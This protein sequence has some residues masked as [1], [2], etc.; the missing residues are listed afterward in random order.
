MIYIHRYQLF[1]NQPANAKTSSL[2]Q[3]GGLIKWVDPE[4]NFG[5]A[6]LCPWP[7]LG[8]QTLEQELLTQGKLFQRSIELAKSDLEARKNKIKLISEVVVQ[9]HLLIQDYKSFDFKNLVQSIVKIKGDQ[10]YKSLAEV[11]N[12]SVSGFEK[13]RLD[14]NFCLTESE[15]RDFLSLLNSDL[16]KKIE[17]VEDPFLFELQSWTELNQTVRLSLDWSELQSADAQSWPYTIAKPARKHQDSFLYMTSSMDHPVG[18]AHGLAQ[19]Q[20]WPEKAHGFL[21][22]SSYQPTEF[23]SAFQQSGTDLKYVS[24]GFGIGFE[25]ALQNISWEPWIDWNLNSENQLFINPKITQHEKNILFELNDYFKTEVS[26]DGYFLIPSSG[27]SKSI[28][29]SVKLIALK[30][31]AVLN[32]ARRVN[33]QFGFTQQMSWG[34]VLPTFHVGG[35]GIL[36]RSYLAKSKVFFCEWKTLLID[37]NFTHWINQNN[38]Q[39]LSL[40]PAQIYDLVKK[41]IQC[42]TSIQTVFVGGSELLIDVAAAAHQLKWPLVQTYGMTETASMV[43]YKDDYTKKEF[44]LM[45]GVRFETLQ[46]GTQISC[47]SLASYSLQKVKNVIQITSFDSVFQISDQISVQG[48]TFQFS[49]RNDDKVQILSETVSM[50]ELRSRLHS[51]LIEMDEDLGSYTLVAL[52]D[53]RTGHRLVLVTETQ[54]SQ[55]FEKF[56]SIVRPYERAQKSVHMQKIPKTDLGKVKY[57]ELIDKLSQSE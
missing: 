4:G 16:L 30:K 45:N 44:Q 57:A 38:I 3:C 35:L 42:P 43:A 33:E 17:T 47:D 9:N 20:M 8:D 31:S 55:V 12:S 28:D 36:A 2:V 14:F 6:D 41:N 48:S 5:V 22:L 54:N 25:S 21:T 49:G 53:P 18:V 29:E 24:D 1:R 23:H 51:L 7:S 26:K 13:I 32:S 46:A 10:D 19:A 50:S 27:S 15:F 56:N 37:D 34:C 40:V 39:V 11:L 52:P